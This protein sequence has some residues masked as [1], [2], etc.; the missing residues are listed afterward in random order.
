MAT[1]H[2]THRAHYNTPHPGTIQQ[3]EQDTVWSRER[4]ASKFRKRKVANLAAD[5]CPVSV[6]LVPVCFGSF[7][8]LPLCQ[9]MDTGPNVINWGLCGVQDKYKKEK[10]NTE[11]KTNT[12]KETKAF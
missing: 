10:L 11:K 3:T 9:E 7:G 4:V 5:V 12:A 6:N 8:R 2:Q 1:P